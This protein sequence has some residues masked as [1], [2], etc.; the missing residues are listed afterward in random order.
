M[1]TDGVAAVPPSSRPVTSGRRG[2]RPSQ[3]QTCANGRRG[4]RPS[5]FQTCANGRRGS[6]PSQFQTCA[7]G[8]R[9]S[10][11]S[12]FI[13]QGGRGATRAGEQ[14]GYQRNEFNSP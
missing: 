1:P 3:F 2:S 4:S 11:P 9:G 8:R 6:R 10:R 12:Q 13:A 7:A 5:Q 14:R